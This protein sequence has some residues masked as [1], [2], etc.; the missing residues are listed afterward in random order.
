LVLFTASAREVFLRLE[1]LTTAKATPTKERATEA[2][3]KAETIATVDARAPSRGKFPIMRAGSTEAR[4][5]LFG[6]DPPALLPEEVFPDPPALIVFANVT[7][8]K[9]KV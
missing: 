4:I 9:V 7:S 5:P 1:V 2:R 6:S 8:R 3:A